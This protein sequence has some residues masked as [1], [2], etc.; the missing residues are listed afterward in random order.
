MSATGPTE[1]YDR[2]ADKG[3][4][5]DADA[6]SLNVAGAPEHAQLV[7]TMHAELKAVVD[8]WY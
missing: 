2:R 4:S 1:L 3:A 7:A 5:F 6:Y 8:S